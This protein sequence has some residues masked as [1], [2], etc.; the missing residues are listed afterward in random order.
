MATTPDATVVAVFEE[1]SD[2][3]SAAN[4]LKN[5]GFGS[6]K[7]YLSS[8]ASPA[9][10]SAGS[11]GSSDASSTH[12]KGGISG[13]FKNLFGEDEHPHRRM[14][15]SAVSG[16]QTLLSVKAAESQIPQVSEILERYSPVDVRIDEIGEARGI[17]TPNTHDSGY[18]GSESDVL[19]ARE[20]LRGVQRGGVRVY[21]RAGET[22]VQEDVRRQ[23]P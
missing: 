3:R 13:W 4:D 14:Y 15:E 23:K 10:E 7:V 16:G 12:H 21:S 6:D 8:D 5:A 22:P 19:N 9:G 18:Q 2:A 1:A 20:E 17:A 11:P